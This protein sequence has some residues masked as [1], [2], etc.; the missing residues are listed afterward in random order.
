MKTSA[1]SSR[2]LKMLPVNYSLLGDAGA[3]FSKTQIVNQLANAQLGDIALFHMNHPEKPVAEGVIAGVKALK[4][5]KAQGFSAKGVYSMHLNALCDLE[6]YT[7]QDVI[8]QSVH[9]KNE[10]LAFKIL[11]ILA[12]AQIPYPKC[13]MARRTT[14]AFLPI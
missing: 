8:L 12:H 11:I 13:E 14:S 6:D 2:I 9:K 10:Y 5:L 4:A 7:Y 1:T 3:T